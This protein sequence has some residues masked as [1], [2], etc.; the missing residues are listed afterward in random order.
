MG[1][2]RA[3]DPDEPTGEPSDDF[4]QP[5]NLGDVGDYREPDDFPAAA[6]PDTG[7]IPGPRFPNRPPD[8]YAADFP[9]VPGF[10]DYTEPTRD[11]PGDYPQPE[12]EH[13]EEDLPRSEVDTPDDFPDF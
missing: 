11:H 8:E 4:P 2:H 9:D 5:E 7:S 3:P 13:H 10:F 1:R 12:P 6:P